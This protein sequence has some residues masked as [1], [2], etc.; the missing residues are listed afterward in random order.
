MKLSAPK[1]VTWWNTVVLGVIGLLG[2]FTANLPVIGAYTGWL[3]ALA[4]IILAIATLV[5]GF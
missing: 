4:F 5:E 3:L 1:V 2:L